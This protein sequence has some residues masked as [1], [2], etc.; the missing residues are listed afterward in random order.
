MRTHEVLRE[1]TL[2]LGVRIDT[3]TC[4]ADAAIKSTQFSEAC[5]N[6]PNFDVGIDNHCHTLLSSLFFQAN[7][8]AAVTM[9]RREV[10]FENDATESSLF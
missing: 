7:G 3:Y 1:G 4:A 5:T 10:P 9:P 6:G 2:S 8:D